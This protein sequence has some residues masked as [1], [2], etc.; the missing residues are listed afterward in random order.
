MDPIGKSPIALPFLL[1]GKVSVF[2]CWLFFFA[3][4][5]NIEMLYDAPFTRFIAFGLVLSGFSILVLG[6]V[7]LGKSV[8]VGLLREET[9]L[10]TEGIY[11]ITR[12]PMYLGGFFIC[13]GSCFYSIHPVNFL[14]CALAVG[15]HHR[16]VLKEEQ[17]LEQRFGTRWL[18]YAQKAPRYIG[19][20]RTGKN[21]PR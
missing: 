16:I 8:S 2:C 20:I 12:N 4:S 9:T 10:K 7:F 6:F 11:G 1:L 3:G 19:R 5:F 21:N 15:I 18:D 13:A 14:L 17:F